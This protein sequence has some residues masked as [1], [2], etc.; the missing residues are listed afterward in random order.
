MCQV[1]LLINE[2]YPAGATLRGARPTSAMTSIGTITLASDTPQ[3]AH[4]V[5]GGQQCAERRQCERTC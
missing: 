4:P 5:T 1:H 2:T 3:I